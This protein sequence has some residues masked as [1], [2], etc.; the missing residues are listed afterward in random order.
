MKEIKHDNWALVHQGSG[1]PVTEGEVVLDF[2]GD[3]D[4]V[5]GGR[6]P[7]KQSSSGFVWTD[8]G[9]EFY[10]SV[11]GLQWVEKKDMVKQ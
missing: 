4:T 7:H 9:A 10:P 8:A 3:A 5:T 6:P 2:R 1:R 11:F